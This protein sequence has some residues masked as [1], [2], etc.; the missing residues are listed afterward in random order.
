MRVITRLKISGAL[1]VVLVQVG[2][3]SMKKLSDFHSDDMPRASISEGISIEVDDNS[4]S[5][6]SNSQHS[7]D[8]ESMDDSTAAYNNKTDQITVKVYFL[9]AKEGGQHRASICLVCYTG[10]TR[11]GSM[12]CRE[13]DVSVHIYQSEARSD[14]CFGES[15]VERQRW[16]W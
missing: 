7:L 12:Q 11:L 3:S 13:R 15:L 14:H 2:S 10:S 8:D 1:H 4:L 16:W 5:N 6:H 9:N